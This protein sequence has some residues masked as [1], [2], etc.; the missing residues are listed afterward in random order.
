MGS[1]QPAGKWTDHRVTWE[2]QIISC[3]DKIFKD[4]WEVRMDKRL[5][6]RVKDAAK[7]KVTRRASEDAGYSPEG[8]LRDRCF[9]FSLYSEGSSVACRQGKLKAD[10][11]EKVLVSQFNSSIY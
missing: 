6:Q 3:S 11:S 1:R 4:Q 5:W 7:A 10:F 2:N 9:S 8:P